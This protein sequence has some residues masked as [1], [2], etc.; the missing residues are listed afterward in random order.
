[1]GAKNIISLNLRY[2]KFM[3][4]DVKHQPGADAGF[5]DWGGGT[6]K[7]QRVCV[8][9]NKQCLHNNIHADDQNIRGSGSAMHSGI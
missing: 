9:L 4:P 7:R 8:C 5:V 6:A 2:C 3:G 1:M